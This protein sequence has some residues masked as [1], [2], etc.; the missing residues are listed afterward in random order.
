MKRKPAENARSQTFSLHAGERIARTRGTARDR[1]SSLESLLYALGYSATAQLWR[2][3]TAGERHL[4]RLRACMYPCHMPV[5]PNTRNLYIRFAIYLRT[6]LIE[7]RRY[8]SI[9]TPH[10]PTALS[11]SR[12]SPTLGDSF[13]LYKRTEAIN[14]HYFST[15]NYFFVRVEFSWINVSNLCDRYKYFILEV[16]KLTVYHRSHE[17]ALQWISFSGSINLHLFMETMNTSPLNDWNSVNGQKSLSPN[18]VRWISASA[19]FSLRFQD[20]PRESSAT[21]Q[22]SITCE[23]VPIHFGVGIVL[24]KVD[25]WKLSVNF[26]SI[27]IKLI[28]EKVQHIILCM[29]V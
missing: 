28:A 13:T 23:S 11:Q 21:L 25:V 9:L 29:R 2:Q 24:S 22:S 26:P 8:R 14:F 27:Q 10:A 5:L 17:I 4:S 3:W 18:R 19:L 15:N 6:S 12:L 7:D 16:I 1:V 20:P